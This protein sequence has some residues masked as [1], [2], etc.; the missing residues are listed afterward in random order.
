MRERRALGEEVSKKTDPYCVCVPPTGPWTLQ[1][2]WLGRGRCLNAAIR[3]GRRGKGRRSATKDSRRGRSAGPPVDIRGS[4]GAEP[5]TACGMLRLRMS[6][7]STSSRA[8][9]SAASWRRPGREGA[10]EGWAA[11]PDRGNTGPAAGWP[12]ALSAGSARR[13][14]SISI[15]IGRPRSPRHHDLLPHAASV[16]PSC[17]GRR[18]TDPRLDRQR[19]VPRAWRSCFPVRRARNARRPG[20]KPLYASPSLRRLPDAPRVSHV[21]LEPPET[22]I[23]NRA[24]CSFVPPAP[25]PAASTAT[26]PRHPSTARGVSGRPLPPCPPSSTP[27]SSPNWAR[28]PVLATDSFH[29]QTSRPAPGRIPSPR[30]MGP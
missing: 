29:L 9:P 11:C 25:H 26:P 3:A 28:R 21:S 6:T 24:V 2:P 15:P 5:S 1:T 10:A 18:R 16:R 30:A 7:R 23:Q 20:Q 4:H 22:D 19:H 17:S 12:P 13:K 8:A 27:S 14:A